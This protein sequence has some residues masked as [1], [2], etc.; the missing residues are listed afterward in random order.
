M[1]A[2]TRRTK[3]ESHTHRVKDESAVE[4]GDSASAGAT[5]I[6]PSE[7]STHTNHPLSQGGGSQVLGDLAWAI[8][9]TGSW[10]VWV[11]NQA[12]KG[13][14]VR[15]L[16][17]S[18]LV[19]EHPLSSSVQR[20]A[21]GGGFAALA[22]GQELHLLSACSGRLVL[23]PIVLVSLPKHLEL[24]AAGQLVVLSQDASLIVWDL[25]S[26]SCQVETSLQ[27]VCS[28]ADIELLG[29]KPTT[30]EP[31]IHLKDQRLLLFHKGFQR[32][33][34]L[35]SLCSS[36]S[37][38]PPADPITDGPRIEADLLVAA[39][40]GAAEEFRE[41]LSALVKFYVERNS[42]R[43]RGWCSALAGKAINPV[44]AWS[45]LRTELDNMGISGPSLLQEIVLPILSAVPA[46]QELRAE[47]AFIGTDSVPSTIF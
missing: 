27:H 38:P 14:I 32:W 33:I 10:E 12:G 26:V 42:E 13:I 39:C 29:V 18:N 3:D 25:N 16:K 44:P 19:W 2:H 11:Q 24:T 41:K 5:M 46:V 4:K 23:P 21:L 35:T 47:V 22:I 7:H 36:G 37:K 40:F 28:P 20:L 8:Y 43:L 45:W 9:S 30:A 15:G 6:Q 31:F 1:R 17:D 34:T